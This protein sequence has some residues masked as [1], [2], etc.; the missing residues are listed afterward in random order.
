MAIENVMPY[1]ARG[2]MQPLMAC[3]VLLGESGHEMP[4]STF[5]LHAKRRGIAIVKRG[6]TPYVSFADAAEIHRDWV[7]SRRR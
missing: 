7:V 3:L 4:A 1:V 2:D 6:R 5:R